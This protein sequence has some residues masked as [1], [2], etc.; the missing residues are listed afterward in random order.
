MNLNK[1]QAD[2]VLILS[3]LGIKESQLIEMEDYD[4]IAIQESFL[5]P[6]ECSPTQNGEDA[7][8][9][10]A[11][12]RESYSVEIFR[13]LGSNEWSVK[14]AKENDSYLAGH[15]DLNL[16][17]CF[18]ALLSL[19]LDYADT[20]LASDGFAEVKQK[21]KYITF[22]PKKDWDLFDDTGFQDTDGKAILVGENYRDTESAYNIYQIRI[23]QNQPVIHW[24]GGFMILTENKA[25]QLKHAPLASMLPGASLFN[26]KIID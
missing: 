24:G 25:R 17:I 20:I 14:L 23:R 12:L 9:L 26:S 8:D 11:K 6:R 10:L 21:G 15:S 3:F 19:N 18:A 4:K 7:L 1:T 22:T 16:A 13:V 5:E 2:K